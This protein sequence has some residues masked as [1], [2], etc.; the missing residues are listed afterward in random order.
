LV[1]TAAICN[2]FGIQAA[3]L[4]YGG[5]ALTTAAFN[6]NV[7]AN[8]ADEAASYVISGR[9][10]TDLGS[11]V[12]NNPKVVDGILEFR[13]TQNGESLRAEIREALLTDAASEFAASINSGLSRTIPPGVLQN[14]KDKMSTLL[15]ESSRFTP[16]PAVWTNEWQS[17]AVTRRWR[18][19]SRE[20]L[21]RL[22]RS[23]NI[24]THDMC[25]CGSGDKLRDCCLLPLHT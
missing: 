13:S 7:G 10:N 2:E 25:P 16:T 20:Y 12:E 6:V 1:Q 5:E 23:R 9:Y 21:L 14:A 3:K 11:F 17:D 4:P 22:C 8:N 19:K 24:T 18:D 15:T